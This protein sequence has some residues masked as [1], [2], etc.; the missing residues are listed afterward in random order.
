M[1]LSGFKVLHHSYRSFI[2]IASNQTKLISLANNLRFNF[3]RYYCSESITVTFKLPDG[4]LIKRSGKA[5]ETVRS[6][7]KEDDPEFPGYGSCNG[8]I[9]VGPR[10]NSLKH[11]F[12]NLVTQG[13]RGDELEKGPIFSLLHHVWHVP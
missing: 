5:G 1:L 11:D 9:V 2:F 7:V 8:G 6:T 4:T 10:L 3:L 12:E 13:T